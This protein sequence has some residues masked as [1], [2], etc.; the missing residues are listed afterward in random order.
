MSGEALRVI[1]GSAPIELLELK[2][3]PKILKKNGQNSQGS[4][5]YDKLNDMTECRMST[6]VDFTMINRK[7]MRSGWP[8]QRVG[9]LPASCIYHYCDDTIIMCV[10][11]T[12]LV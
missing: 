10:F 5:A 1:S 9:V 12:L 11:L 7:V 6:D 2:I 4:Y 3:L 8:Y